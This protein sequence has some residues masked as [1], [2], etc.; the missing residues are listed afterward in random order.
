VNDKLIKDI[1]IELNNSNYPI[2][3]KRLNAITSNNK[4]IEF[5]H[6]LRGD[7][8]MGLKDHQNA[9]NEYQKSFDKKYK[10]AE[11]LLGIGIVKHIEGKYNE[12][13]KNYDAS[14]LIKETDKAWAQLGLLYQD[15]LGV[16][17][18][19]SRALE[20][21]DKSIKINK[22]TGSK[23][24]GKLL[25]LQGKYYNS[26]KTFLIPFMT[27]ND[28]FKLNP[29]HPEYLNF[30]PLILDS[31]N[32]IAVKGGNINKILISILEQILMVKED[33]TYKNI[34][35]KFAK[36]SHR[37]AV[38]AAIATKVREIMTLGFFTNDLNAENAG[39]QV[40]KECTIINIDDCKPEEVSKN[41]AILELINS[42]IVYLGLKHHK[43]G[44]PI[45]E[46]FFKSIRKLLLKAAIID[47][48]NFNQEKNFHS[49][50]KA[51]A[52]QSFANEYVWKVSKEEESSLNELYDKILKKISDE[53]TITINSIFLLGSYKKL[54]DY[55]ELKNVFHKF[56]SDKNLAEII[57]LQILDFE[58]EF[59]IKQTIE[60]I[61]TIEDE[62]SLDVRSQYEDFP[63]PRWESESLDAYTMNNYVDRIERDIFPNVLLKKNKINNVLIAGCGTGYQAI[64]SAKT[65]KNAT[66]Y[67]LD[68]SKTSLSYGIRSAR[69]LGIK[70]IKWFHG[71]ILNLDSF[72][73]DFSVIECTGVLHHM[74]NPKNAFNML[75]NKLVPNGFFKLALYAKKYRD[76]LIPEKSIINEQKLKANLQDVR[77]ARDVIFKKSFNDGTNYSCL[78]L[79]DFYSTSEFIDLLM[80]KK[81]LSFTIEG[82]KELFEDNYNFLGFV[83]ANQI[84][85]NKFRNIYLKDTKRLNLNNWDEFEKNNPETFRAMYQMWLQKK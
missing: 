75:S 32:S 20:Y 12:A 2:A 24:K 51:L 84:I 29:H 3:L 25:F 13:K 79:A 80:H 81:E 11:S 33:I 19:E 47:L 68:I 77:K 61:G 38:V 39:I 55:P 42:K 64:I 63:Y 60:S 45:V 57:K 5:E 72:E 43:A 17:R 73:K 74:N 15:G 70:N 54:F 16:E 85:R 52:Y 10:Q 56:K 9:I 28:H 41:K 4:G 46:L 48:D 36:K 82:L 78:R 83:I 27:E 53:K 18:D 37:T 8:F 34:S 50:L 35:D 40:D 6:L 65:D 67:A 44:A 76:L 69:D 1:I 14:L 23:Q 58:E 49:I 21:F 66:I 30:L 7:I 71:D 26:I 31:I 22:V 62:I 59:K